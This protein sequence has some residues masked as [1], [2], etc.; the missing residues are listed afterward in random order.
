MYSLTIPGTRSPK[1]DQD[2]GK[3]CAASEDSGTVCPRAFL[4]ASGGVSGPGLLFAFTHLIAGSAWHHMALSSASPCLFS[5]YENTSRWIKA[6]SNQVWLHLN[7]MAS[8]KTPFLSNGLFTATGGSDF[9][10]FTRSLFFFFWLCWVLVAVRAFLL[11]WQMGA[12]L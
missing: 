4:L 6:H 8:A 12:S 9:N 10:P 11:L 3:G 7:L 1:G 2:V 5:S